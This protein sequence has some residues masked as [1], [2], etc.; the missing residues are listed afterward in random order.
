MPYRCGILLYGPPGTGKASFTAALAGRFKL[1]LYILS[2]SDA[3]LDDQALEYLFETL[4][5]Q[6]IILL[7]D[8]DSAG[9]Q[10]ASML[11]SRPSKTAPLNKVT[12]SGLL[13]AID[14][15]AAAEGRILIMT[16]NAP[17]SLDPALIRSGRIDHEAKLGTASTYVAKTLFKR[18]FTNADGTSTVSQSEGESLDELA[19]KFASQI[20]ELKL[21]PAEIQGFLL[22]HRRDPN[23]AVERANSWAEE[24]IRNKSQHRNVAEFE[25]E[26]TSERGGVG[27]VR[28][29][30]EGGIAIG[31]QRRYA[32]FPSAKNEGAILERFQDGQQGDQTPPT[33]EETRERLEALNEELGAM[34]DHPRLQ[35]K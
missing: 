24:R 4:P 23:G 27:G 16:T 19:V 35:K 31:F 21:S 25:D 28:G 22:D 11:D 33:I 18:I 6:C 34:I 7:E 3:A 12:L 17:E 10:R 1:D 30:K 14:G 2:F 9:I 26:I 15:V 13:N 20:P 8:I 29:K 32:S 5:E